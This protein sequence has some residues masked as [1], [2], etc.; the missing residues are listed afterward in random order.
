[1]LR[2]I[3]SQRHYR[4]LFV[5]AL[6][7]SATPQAPEPPTRYD[8]SRNLTVLDDGV[9]LVEAAAHSGTETLTKNDGER[10]DADHAFGALSAGTMTRTGA[11]GENSDADAPVSWGTTEVSTR[12]LPAD[13]EKDVYIPS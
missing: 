5:D 6:L 11:R 3:D 8:E 7:T 13:V 2:M 9:P 10:S 12:K 1:M 4:T